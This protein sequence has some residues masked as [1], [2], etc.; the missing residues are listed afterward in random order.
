MMQE[1]W[2]VL[3]WGGILT[4]KVPRP[5]GAVSF[6]SPLV[7]RFFPEQQFYCFG[8]SE[9]RLEECSHKGLKWR[10]D[11]SWTDFGTRFKIIRVARSEKY[12]TVAM[13][14]VEGNWWESY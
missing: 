2:R 8:V 10:W 7:Q 9:E 6:Q 14:K 11:W 5:D 13:E 1:A 4:V 12:M 3:E